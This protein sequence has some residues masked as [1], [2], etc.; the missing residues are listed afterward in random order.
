MFESSATILSSTPYARSRAYP[1]S[2]MKRS[3]NR[4]ERES[5]CYLSSPCSRALRFLICHTPLSHIINNTWCIWMRCPFMPFRTL[6]SVISMNPHAISWLPWT[7]DDA[8]YHDDMVSENSTDKT[9]CKPY[10]SK[11]MDSRKLWRCG[12]VKPA[13][14][15]IPTSKQY[16]RQFSPENNQ[17]MVSVSCP[18]YHIP[19]K[20]G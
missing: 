18:S 8:I 12:S 20:Q 4:N 11:D 15:Y 2:R 7:H 9:S 5:R 19:V 17:H 10:I 14:L 1:D 13:S 16:I 3:A 6:A